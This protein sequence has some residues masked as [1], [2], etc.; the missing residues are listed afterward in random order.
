[1]SQVVV[2][3]RDVEC[4]NLKKIILLALN[5]HVTHA[6]KFIYFCLCDNLD[7]I[8][9]TFHHITNRVVFLLDFFEFLTS[10][11][12]SKKYADSATHTGPDPKIILKFSFYLLNSISTF[13]KSL[14]K[15]G[16][17]WRPVR[18]INFANL[19]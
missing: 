11:R 17:S 3:G 14:I 18:P 10:M 19:T 4:E 13:A 7:N 6:L 2:K 5:V 12:V 1:M 8:P 9:K 15:L 16:S